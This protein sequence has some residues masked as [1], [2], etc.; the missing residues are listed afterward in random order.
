MKEMIS[1]T[2]EPSSTKAGSGSVV[3]VVSSKLRAD[4]IILSIIT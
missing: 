1:S 4:W 3:A 2:S